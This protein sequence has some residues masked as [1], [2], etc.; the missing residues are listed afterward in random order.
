MT[1]EEVRAIRDQV[2]GTRVM[3][4]RLEVAERTVRYWCLWGVKKRLL[5]RVVRGLVAMERSGDAR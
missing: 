4:E 1:P 5:V 2:G 3:A